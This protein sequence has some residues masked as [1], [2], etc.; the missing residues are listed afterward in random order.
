MDMIWMWVYA[1]GMI[2]AGLLFAF[3]VQ[4]KVAAVNYILLLAAVFVGLFHF[5]HDEVGEFGMRVLALALAQ[6]GLDMVPAVGGYISAF[7]GGWVFFLLPI[8]LMLALR[9]FWHKRLA[10]LFS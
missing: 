3:E 4:V 1:I 5:N 9:F 7:F 10:P 6:R 8:V 2:A